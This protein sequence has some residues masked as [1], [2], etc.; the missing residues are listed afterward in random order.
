M[1]N[2]KTEAVKYA[3]S[4]I[5]L[6]VALMVIWFTLNFLHS[7]WGSNPIGKFAGTVGDLASGQKYNFN[8]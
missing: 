7:K 4:L 1:A 5:A 6:I 8:N 2:T 3:Q